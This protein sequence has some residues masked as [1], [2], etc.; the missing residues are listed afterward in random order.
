MKEKWKTIPG[1]DPDFVISTKGR[2]FR[3]SKNTEVAQ[4]LTG[5]PKYKYVN[6]FTEDGERV[7]RRVHNLMGRTF[8][9]NP[10]NLPIVDHIDR[11]KM[12]N[13]LSNLRWTDEF[14]NLRNLDN[15]I[16]IGDAHI[17]EFVE[18]YPKPENAYS[19]LRRLI[20]T[21]GYPCEEAVY[22]YEEYL[23]R[24]FDRKTLVWKDEEF[25]I[26]DFCKDNELDEDKVRDALKRGKELW[27]VVYSC[28][29]SHPSSIEVQ[30]KTGVGIWIPS[31]KYL[32][33]LLGKGDSW[34]ENAMKGECFE[35]WL[36]YD[37]LNHLKYTIL[38][39]TG[40]IPELSKY[41]NLEIN[42]VQARINRKGMSL[43]EA[44]T[45]PRDKIKKVFLDGVAMTT[46]S[47][48]ES[49]GL[50][51]K[52]VNSWRSKQKL[53]PT[54]EETLIRFGVDVSEI[55]LKY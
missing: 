47:M 29:E 36:A 32:K 40:T 54:I 33:E 7:L 27:N 3:I 46:K 53:K 30:S 42:T 18:R 22:R 1:Y 41:F 39:V 44:L 51:Q 2:V 13:D 23:E 38:G 48:Y 6:I 25:Y 19:Y 10:D 17:K 12:N 55:D 15:S 31:R 16:Y 35:D 14:G 9:E 52:T 24:G 11:D 8:L 26:S 34:T 20:Q 37:P 50:N 43:E 5:I 49:L 4:V 28:P 21:E 45:K